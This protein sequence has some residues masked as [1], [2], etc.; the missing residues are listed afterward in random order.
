M[1]GPL[2]KPTDKTQKFR[3]TRGSRYIYYK[4]KSAFSVIW[5]MGIF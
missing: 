4:I 3:E 5:P 1:Y 2:I